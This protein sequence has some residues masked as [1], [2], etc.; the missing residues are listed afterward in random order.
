[1][2]TRTEPD[3]GAIEP[4]GAA[5]RTAA[6]RP[7]RP[8]P[9]TILLMALWMG[10]A[11]GFLDLTILF[12]KKR[13]I[14]GEYFYRLGE[15]FQWIIPTGVTVLVLLPA[16]AIASFASLRRFRVPFGIAVA[17]PAFF[18]FLDICAIL[19]LEPWGALLLSA[20]TAA[21]FARFVGRRQQK[22]L[23][24][25]RW[26]TPLLG[27]ALIFVALATSGARAYIERR[28]AATLP[29][30]SPG[31]RNVLLIVWDTVRAA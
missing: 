8:S 31:A 29:P 6:A 28:A 9:A 27:A 15:G 20:G 25:V 24:V 21:Q 19:P 2:V 22:F 11:A 18:G 23:M 7:E 14:D 17:I 3:A 30:P 16:L 10:L 4:V 12:F 1:M 13:F 5:I 26:T